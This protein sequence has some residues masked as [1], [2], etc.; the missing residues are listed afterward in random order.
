[1]YIYI[2]VLS[3]ALH[4]CVIVQINPLTTVH[5]HLYMGTNLIHVNICCNVFMQDFS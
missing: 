5:V 2:H 4:L 3:I 1:M